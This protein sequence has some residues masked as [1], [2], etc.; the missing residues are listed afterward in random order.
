MY[1]LLFYL[2][3]CSFICLS[4]V[5]QGQDL[6]I[7][8][9]GDTIIQF[10]DGSWRYYT[11]DDK[12]KY[13][14][15][16]EGNAEIKAHGLDDLLRL[17]KLVQEEVHLIT[18]ELR[19]I[20]LNRFNLEKSL[21]ETVDADLLENLKRKL[22]LENYNHSK[23]RSSLTQYLEMSRLI[24]NLVPNYTASKLIRYQKIML[25]YQTAKGLPLSNFGDVAALNSKEKVD[26]KVKVNNTQNQIPNGTPK[27][28]RQKNKDIA[29]IEASPK[30]RKSNIRN[31]GETKAPKIKNTR[32][33]AKPK[34]IPSDPG[35]NTGTYGVGVSAINSKALNK[36]PWVDQINVIKH[37]DCLVNSE[38]TD[39][40]TQKKRIDLGKQFLFSYTDE[41]LR[42]FL[43]GQEL[44][45]CDASLT[46]LGGFS[47]LNLSFNI[48]SPN[49]RDNFGVLEN[50]APISLKLINGNTI[51]LYNSNRDVGKIDPYS[52]N[53]VYNGLYIISAA[54]EKLLSKTEL[55]ELRVIWSTGYEDYEIYEIDFFINQLTCLKKSKVT[56]GK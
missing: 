18:Q 50:N 21:K 13:G 44:L 12:A 29:V 5:V 19:A 8:E 2:I 42:P 23:T 46:S 27:E 26:K 31:P 24:E 9:K 35:S 28:K 54:N 6:I 48:A 3:S 47:Y 20:N 37:T 30:D 56:T 14:A 45:I 36:L 41:K 16:L 17:Q 1:K 55:D 32:T 49:A 15:Q 34:S 22:R 38:K 52:G 51:S 10:N 39:D 4:T 33:N 43:K 53:T 7:N 11:I 25:T 40:F